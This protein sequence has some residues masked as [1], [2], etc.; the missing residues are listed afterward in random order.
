MEPSK[1]YGWLLILWLLF[2]TVLSLMKIGKIPSITVENSDKYVHFIFYFI[3]A[4]LTYITLKSFGVSFYKRVLLSFVFSVVY[5]III[6]VLQE[7]LTDTRRFEWADIVA[8][9]T[10][11]IISLLL[12]SVLRSKVNF[13]K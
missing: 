6:E 1:K 12:I 2:V 9:A 10:G 5:G 4:F 11:A 13:L 3:T 7:V 8:N